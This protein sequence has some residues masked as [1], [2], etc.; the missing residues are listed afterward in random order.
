MV[1]D[2]L[3]DGYRTL[4]PSGRPFGEAL[5]DPTVIYA[6]FVRA[7]LESDA[8]L[9]YLSHI[10]GHGLLKLMRPR[11]GLT[12]EITKLPEVPEVLA[13]LAQQAD[14]SPRAA[15]STFNMG[16]GFAVYCAVGAGEG[17]VRRASALG[18]SAHIAGSVEPGPRRV[19]LSEVDVVF[20]SADMDLSPRRAA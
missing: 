9:H 4:L 1:A 6:Q 15:Y 19:I 2:R 10:T 18:L 17:V 3:P 5:L 11:C 12:Y 13:F 20:E 7:L 14:M 16:C 8:E